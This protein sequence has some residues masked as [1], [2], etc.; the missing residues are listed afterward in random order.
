MNKKVKKQ[1]LK[2]LRSGEYKQTTNYLKNS[3]A[4]CCL[5]IL[6]DIHSKEKNH[7]WSVGESYFSQNRGLPDQVLKWAN[8]PND[9]RYVVYN[10]KHGQ[11][12]NANDMGLSFKQIAN[13]IEKQL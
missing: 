9:N 11:L 2:A 6:C 1:W 5:G 4:Y 10:G 3:D 7:K 12:G 8:L 13:I